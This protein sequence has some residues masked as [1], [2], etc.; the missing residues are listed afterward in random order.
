LTAVDCRS[1]PGTTGPQGTQTKAACRL[2][3]ELSRDQLDD[4]LDYTNRAQGTL[5]SASTR[6]L[7]VATISLTGGEP[8]GRLND[9]FGQARR[10]SWACNCGD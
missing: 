8:V 6:E 10:L 7:T 2:R 3:D 4:K 1:R 5:A 9:H